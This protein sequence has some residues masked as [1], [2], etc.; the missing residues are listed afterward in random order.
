MPSKKVWIVSLSIAAHAAVFTTAFV[1]NAWR[2][3]RLDPERQRFSLAVLPPPPAPSG[4]P[5][6]GEKPKDPVPPTKRVAQDPTQ[7]T[8]QPKTAPPRAPAD[9]D[10]GGGDGKTKGPGDNPDGD[11]LDTG[12]CTGP[13]CGPP[14]APPAEPPPVVEKPPVIEKPTIVPPSTLRRLSGDTA[15]AP[16]DVT[17]TQMLRDDHRRVVG[18]FK[19]CLND[20]GR[21]T[22]IGTVGSTRYPD[23]DQKLMAA[24]RGWVYAPYLIAGRP[25]P[26]CSA[27]SF[28]YTME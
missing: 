5:R 24:M 18:S 15:I 26:V 20:T 17:K 14:S 4:G 2:V 9:D 27:V 10:G 12:S 23:Y 19:I 28:V 1:T 11:P 3:E 13:A 22:S 8:E 6:P 25:A 21:V 7:P 16:S